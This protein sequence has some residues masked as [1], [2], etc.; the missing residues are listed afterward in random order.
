[1]NKKSIDVDKN[2]FFE[3]QKIIEQGKQ[4]VAQAINSGLSATYWHIGKRIN[5]EIL[6]N[7]RADYG[8]QVVQLLSTRLVEEYGSGFST[9]NLRHM[10][11]FAEVF[12]D[13]Q[14]VSS[15]IRQLSWTHFTII[16]YQETDLYSPHP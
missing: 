1:M 4:H 10:M 9:K 13:F 15:L 2:L 11:K 5:D 6:H 14:I 3:I 8:K 16:I 7:K 12:P